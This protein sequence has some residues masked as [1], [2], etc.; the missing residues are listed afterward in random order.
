MGGFSLGRDTLSVRSVSRESSN[1]VESSRFLP[2]DVIFLNRSLN[3]SFEPCLVF[4]G[5]RGV[6]LSEDSE[7][8]IGEEGRL[9]AHEVVG[10]VAVEDLLVVLDL[11]QEVLN[12]AFCEIYVSIG[13]KSE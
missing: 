9:R 4:F 2:Y 12:D 5:S 3:R 1:R 13:E 7:S 11:E 8:E 6:E 10:T